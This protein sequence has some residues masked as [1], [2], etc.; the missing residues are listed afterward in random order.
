MFPLIESGL[1]EVVAFEP[2]QEAYRRLLINLAAND[3]RAVR[4]FNAA[5]ARDAGFRTFFEPRNH[6][7]NGSFHK[8]FSQIFSDDVDE[9]TV[10]WR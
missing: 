6:L 7:T 3:A 10:L 9:W 4:T 8:E 2:S 5:V 1:R